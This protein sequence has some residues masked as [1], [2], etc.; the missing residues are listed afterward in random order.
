[1]R[2]AMKTSYYLYIIIFIVIAI[3]RIC[4]VLQA[5]GAQKMAEQQEIVNQH[6]QT[7]SIMVID[8]KKERLSEANMPAAIAEKLPRI[9][10][11][12]KMPIVKAKVGNQVVN[13]LCDEKVF[14]QIPEKKMVRVEVAG[15]FIV[16]IKRDKR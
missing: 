10:R 15:I 16:G 1:M 12:K 8:K 7:V 11:M 9:V 3:M 6:K 2:E 4:A 14:D 13:L 5:P